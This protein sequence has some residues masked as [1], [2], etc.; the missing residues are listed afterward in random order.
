[1]SGD[2]TEKGAC[3]AHTRRAQQARKGLHIHFEDLYDIQRGHIDVRAALCYFNGGVHVVGFHDC[4]TRQSIGSFLAGYAIGGYAGWR[5]HGDAPVDDSVAKIV[6]PF[7]VF[8][9]I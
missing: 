1:M 8:L 4:Q 5:S 3:R 2:S 6:K 7:H 9:G